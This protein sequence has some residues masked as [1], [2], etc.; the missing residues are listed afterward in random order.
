MALKR[1]VLMLSC[2]QRALFSL[3]MGD[4]IC[5]IF[6]SSVWSLY[7]FVYS[8]LKNGYFKSYT[9][10]CCKGG[11]LPKLHDDNFAV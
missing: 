10:I 3:L 1:V 5:I 2:L 4:A 7:L 6:S 8:C 11:P 9:K